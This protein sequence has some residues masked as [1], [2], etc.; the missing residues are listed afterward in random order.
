FY[1]VNRRYQVNQ[2][3]KCIL[4]AG[5]LALLL[6]FSGC[7][8]NGAAPIQNGYTSNNQAPLPA[9]AADGNLAPVNNGLANDQT[10]SAEQ[11]PPAQSAG[12]YASPARQIS[13]ASQPAPPPPAESAQEAP[14]PQSAP[15]YDQPAP[16]YDSGDN[17]DNQGYD[18]NSDYDVG[19]Q[20]Q[21][22]P[23][24]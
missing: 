13:Y 23:P 16:P 5:T 2:F 17:Y 24:E 14:Y 7:R 21:E 11:G 18:D 10:A 3:R 19:I 1:G 20:A 22:P 8:Q 15:Q 4:P 6:G 12:N 9:D